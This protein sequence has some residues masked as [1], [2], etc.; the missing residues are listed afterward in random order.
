MTLVTVPG[1]ESRSATHRNWGTLLRNSANNM[2]TRPQSDAPQANF[3]DN[4]VGFHCSP[5]APVRQV[6]GFVLVRTGRGIELGSH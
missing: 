6:D 2:L 4:P 1:A 5:F 3:A